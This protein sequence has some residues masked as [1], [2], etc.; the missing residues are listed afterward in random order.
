MADHRLCPDCG[1]FVIL[2]R[3]D[4]SFRPLDHWEGDLP[5]TV[6]ILNPDKWGRDHLARPVLFIDH[7]CSRGAA[8]AWRQRVD[9]EEQEAREAYEEAANSTCPRC[10]SVPGEPCRSM[11]LRDRDKEEPVY[12]RNFH[13]ER[14]GFSQHN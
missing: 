3:Q 12:N 14:F 4:R 8:T 7:E 11:Q 9:R 1:G 10:G 2:A 5:D 6:W 13:A